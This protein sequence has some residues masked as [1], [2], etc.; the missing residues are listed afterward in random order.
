M[1]ELTGYTHGV[2]LGGW[3]SQCNY[4]K[5]HCDT[6]ITEA[7]IKI[8]K[9]WGMD[10]VRLP[11]DYNMFQDKNGALIEY[12]FT[13]VQN[14]IDWC[15]NNQLNM[16]LD[17]HKTVGY[18]FDAGEKETGLFDTNSTYQGQFLALWK[19]F[20]RRYA[21][22]EDMLCFELLNEVTDQSYSKPWNAL[23]KQC[24]QMIRKSAP[25]IKILV[26]SYWNNSITSV[27]D[28]DPPYDEN[29]IYNFHC[30]D[31]LIFTHQGAPWVGKD[32]NLD[33][34]MPFDAT[35][36][37][38]QKYSDEKLTQMSPSFAGF[39]QDKSPDA[40][41]FETL[42]AETLKIA[43]E[44]NVRLYCG[45]YGVI[46]RVAPEET[47]KWF[48]EISKVFNAHGIGRAVWSYKKMDFG[49]SD[50][51]LDGVRAELLKLL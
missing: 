17:L 40:S 18:S 26:G 36:A 9:S 4:E 45:E 8:I 12:G 6:F 23:A 7:D 49:I 21:K 34:R 44:R 42:F 37:E 15:K 5:S 13:Y 2:N 38:Y 50:Q 24:I 29:I 48:K 27:K 47:L 20:T 46:D 1:K 33:F 31:P 25:T 19:E 41:Y 32:M 16:I 30:Y 39:P 22:Y 43:E 11:V 51:R 3:L 35:F 14:C 10:H 28:L